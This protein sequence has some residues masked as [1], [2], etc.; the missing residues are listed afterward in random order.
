M[1]K[2]QFA[3]Q[4][5]QIFHYWLNK[6]TLY[7]QSKNQPK[8]QTFNGI[9]I[10]ASKNNFKLFEIKVTIIGALHSQKGQV[11]QE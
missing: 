1:K 11:H 2:G 7:L 4:I 3:L 5:N 8:N 9:L 6:S 10:I